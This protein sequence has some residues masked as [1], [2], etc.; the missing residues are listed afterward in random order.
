MQK[1]DTSMEEVILESATRLFV[2]QGFSA[3]STTQIAREA[4]CNQAL[5]HYY[6]RTKERL[7]TAIFE[8]KA[9]GFTRELLRVGESDASFEEKIRM[10]MEAHFEMIQQDPGLPM[11]LFSELH[12]DRKRQQALKEAVS[13]F[14]REAVSQLQE[15]LDTE[16]AAGR[17]RPI[18]VH[19]LI[20][21]MISSTV[22]LFMVRPMLQI[23]TDVTDEDYDVFVRLRKTQNVDMI[24]NSIRP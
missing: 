20:F 15:E 24:L 7:F 16:I 6:Y 10:R 17:V 3:T 5:V 2:A 12:R 9:W 21:L 18:Q 11:L 4:G 8:K 13:S 19:E 23:V 14:N 1:T 22:T